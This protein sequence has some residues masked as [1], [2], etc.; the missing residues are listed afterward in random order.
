VN[1]APKTLRR[2]VVGVFSRRTD[3]DSA[4]SAL[5]AAGFTRSDLSVLA[6]HDS[7]EAA[8][9]DSL[10]WKTRLVGLLGELKY[11]G[12][13]VTAGLIAIAAGPVGAVLGGLIAAG[14]GGAAL[15][16][17]MDEVT[18]HPHAAEFAAALTAGS[19]LLWVDVTSQTDDGKVTNI[20]QSFGATNIHANERS[21]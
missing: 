20:L 13:L 17:L 5:L 10:S 15:K 1:T 18:A 6:S 8:S 21:A 3:F 2:E 11:E 19:V 14:V 4:V 12:P 7:L 9:A 16:E